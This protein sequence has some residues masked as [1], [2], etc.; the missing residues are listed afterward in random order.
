ML[1]AL[2]KANCD[3]V[4]ISFEGSLKPFKITHPTEQNEFIF[5]IVPVRNS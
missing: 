5:I 1:E 2:Q 3:E 4:K